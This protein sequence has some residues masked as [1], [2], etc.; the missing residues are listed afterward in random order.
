[1]RNTYVEFQDRGSRSDLML[2]EPKT[3]AGILDQMLPAAAPIAS[4]LARDHQDTKVAASFQAP[5]LQAQGAEGGVEAY[6]RG[7]EAE[8]GIGIGRNQE[9]AIKS[10][11]DADADAAAQCILGLH[12]EFSTDVPSTSQGTCRAVGL[13][14]KAASNKDSPSMLVSACGWTVM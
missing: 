10:Y 1:M 6:N 8:F 5:D 13:Y 11:K 3:R 9:A 14:E 12:L 4:I 7:L 2:R